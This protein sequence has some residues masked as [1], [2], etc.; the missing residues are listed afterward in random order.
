MPLDPFT[1]PERFDA[2][3]NVVDLT[4]DDVPL[5]VF[6]WD[7]SAL[8]SVD[9][10]SAR[11]RQVQPFALVDW[12]GIIS[13][14]RVVLAHARFLQFQDQ[15]ASVLSAGTDV[16]NDAFRFLPPAGFLPIVYTS[17]LVSRFVN[18]AS[19]DLVA[20]VESQSDSRV[21]EVVRDRLDAVLVEIQKQAI[22]QVLATAGSYGV[23]IAA[24]LG[25]RASLRLGRIDTDSIDFRLASSWYDEAL[26]LDTHPHIDL[27]MPGYHLAAVPAAALLDVVDQRLAD[28]ITEKGTLVSQ[29]GG[30]L[31]SDLLRSAEQLRLARAL[32]SVNNDQF[33]RLFGV[34]PIARLKQSGVSANLISIVRSRFGSTAPS[35]QDIGAAI[36]LNGTA[37]KPYVMFVKRLADTQWL[38]GDRQ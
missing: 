6:D 15:L 11:R 29:L 25:D 8:R 28:V 19:Q 2:L 21:A 4:S 1:F 24:F 7:G 33:A 16:S 27:L 14:R 26:D 31:T 30:Q 5:A 37:D 35:A 38:I 18:D 9:M 3:A 13:D 20:F 10:W 22:D 23:D 12:G 36:Q 34:T 17:E 32:Q